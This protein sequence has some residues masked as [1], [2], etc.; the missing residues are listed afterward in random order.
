M[1]RNQVKKRNL[2]GVNEYFEPNFNAAWPNTVISQ[3]FLKRKR[4]HL[5]RSF[6]SDEFVQ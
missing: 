6:Q 1:R 5:R 4:A 3:S 2:R